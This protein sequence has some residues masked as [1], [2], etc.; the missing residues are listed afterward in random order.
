[1]PQTRFTGLKG[2]EGELNND[3]HLTVNLS[4][5]VRVKC[6]ICIFTFEIV[7]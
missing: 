4:F 2:H 1:M 5:N 6:H 3:L 7:N